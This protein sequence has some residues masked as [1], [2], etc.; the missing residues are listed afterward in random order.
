MAT[1]YL[2]DPWGPS[3]YRL[4]FHRASPAFRTLSAA[5][6]FR[7][8]FPCPAAVEVIQTFRRPLRHSILAAPHAGDYGPNVPPRETWDGTF[9]P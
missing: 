6:A 3:A 1:F 2:K 5:L 4:G 7:A 9:F 8:R